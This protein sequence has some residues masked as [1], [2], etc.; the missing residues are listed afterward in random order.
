AGAAAD[1]LITLFAGETEIKWTSFPGPLSTIFKDKIT[2]SF[3]PNAV[4]PGAV[5]IV[6]MNTQDTWWWKGV[7]FREYDTAGN[8]K[9]DFKIS[10]DPADTDVWDKNNLK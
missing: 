3:E 2:V 9:T 5:E 10:T 6:L 7:Q 1:A 8:I 4:N